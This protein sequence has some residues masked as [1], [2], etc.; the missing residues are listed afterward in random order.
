[1]TATAAIPAQVATTATAAIPAQAATTATTDD[2]AGKSGT[3][4]DDALEAVRDGEIISLNKAIGIVRSRNP[5]KVIDVSLKRRS[6]SDI[7]SFKI[8]SSSGRITTVRMDARTGR[9]V[10]F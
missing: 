1:M 2:S 8:K 10:G 6:L 7:Y 4:Q 5:G 9:I 3:D